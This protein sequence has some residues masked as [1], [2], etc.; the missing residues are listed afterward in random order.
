MYAHSSALTEDIDMASL[1]HGLPHEKLPVTE[2]ENA[3]EP[4]LDRQATV[5]SISFDHTHRGL[6][7]RH[8]QFLAIG[9]TIVRLRSCRI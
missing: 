4:P 6:T 1:R 5:N 9:G 7:N 8:V 3:D 2:V